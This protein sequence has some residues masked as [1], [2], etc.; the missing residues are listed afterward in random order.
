MNNNKKKTKNAFLVLEDGTV[1]QGRY[2][3]AEPKSVEETLSGGDLEE[4]DKGIG[5][6]VFNTGM[7]GYYEILT[8]PSYTGQIVVMTYPHI[9]NYGVDSAWSETAREEGRSLCRIK[10][11]GLVVRKLYRGEVP[12]GRVSLDETLQNDG[13]PGIEQID[14]RGLTL[15]LREAGSLRGVIVRNEMNTLS[16]DTVSAL[17]E[18][19]NRFPS[20]EGRNLL[21]RVGTTQTYQ[22]QQGKDEK[23]GT[24]AVID[25]GIKANILRELQLRNINFQVFP[26][27]VDDPDQILNGKF[28][29]VLLSNGPGDPASLRKQIKFIRR[30][31]EKIPVC[32]ICL[33]HQ[34]IALALNGKTYKM[35]F[36]HHGCNHPVK[37][38]KT[39]KVF[40]TSHNHGFAVLPESLPKDIE[41]RFRNANDNTV[42]GLVHTR[43]PVASVQ[44]HP[45]ASPGPFDSLWIFDE[46]VS[47]MQ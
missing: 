14:T 4:A 25:Y 20:M 3:G 27:D 9:G 12:A 39:G 16:G 46:F 22:V 42:E 47:I 30:I 40:V 15:K 43:L 19:L 33:G 21:H 2:F 41:I 44:F 8:D 45:E 13:I 29:G 38:G 7:T 37:D 32:G 17:A 35:K 26:S 1:F 31:I 6:V 24:V 34:L 28:D 23:N 18:L 11:S 5:E 10:P 36:G